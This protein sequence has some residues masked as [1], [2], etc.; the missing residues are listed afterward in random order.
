[1]SALIEDEVKVSESKFRGFVFTLNN[2]TNDDIDRLTKLVCKYCIWGKETAP[3]TGTPHLQG[4]VYFASA[5]TLSA[6]KKAISTR[7]HLESQRGT[8]DQAIEYCKKA[9]DWTEIG[10]KPLNQKEKGE[11]EIARWDKAKEIAISGGDLKTIPSDIYIRCYGNLKRI[12]M[13]HRAESYQLADTEEEHLWYYGPSGTGK[14]RK[15]REE[16][17][18]AYLK[19]CNK[20]WDDYN[21]QDTVIIEDFDMVHKVLCHHIKIWADRY[22]FPVEVKGGKMDIRPKKIIITSNYHPSEIW[23]TEQDLQPVLRRFKV[24]RFGGI[25]EMC[26]KQKLTH[27]CFN[28]V[29]QEDVN[30]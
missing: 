5:K 27:D 3:E 21:Y 16:N 26:K 23:E 29:T 20:W 14:S 25:S 13:E 11:S 10:S 15:A 24:V 12:A 1:M 8:F 4:Y 9:G 19:M 30:I 6:A 17:P 22:P 7:C 18:D 28:Q 2:Y